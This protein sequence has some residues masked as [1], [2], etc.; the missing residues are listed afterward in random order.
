MNIDAD[1]LDYPQRIPN[2]ADK[3]SYGGGSF[4]SQGFDRLQQ[5]YNYQRN[6][7]GNQFNSYAMG[8]GQYN[9][10][11]YDTNDQQ[12]D[13]KIRNYGGSFLSNDAAYNG[14]QYN[15][16]IYNRRETVTEVK[17]G[18]GADYNQ[19]QENDDDGFLAEKLFND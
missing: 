7:V 2:D 18:G 1:D 19:N 17:R 6:N 11:A 8:E 3:Q 15:E 5:E 16:Q 14:Y 4:F 10:A 12:D 13:E 9:Q